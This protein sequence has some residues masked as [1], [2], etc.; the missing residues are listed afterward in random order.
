MHPAKHTVSSTPGQQQTAENKLFFD[1][2]PYDAGCSG[3]IIEQKPTLLCIQGL[4][5]ICKSPLVRQHCVLTATLLAKTLNP[6]RGQCLPWVGRQSRE[7]CRMACSPLI[8][9]EKNA[10]AKSGFMVAT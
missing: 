7:V 8:Q 5:L 3:I 9:L 6:V 1:D 10:R 4:P 2:V